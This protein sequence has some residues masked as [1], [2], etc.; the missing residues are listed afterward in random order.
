MEHIRPGVMDVDVVVSVR[1]S[2][3][4]PVK[5]S[6]QYENEERGRRMAPVV[7]VRSMIDLAAGAS[8]VVH[9]HGSINLG[10]YV[11]RRHR[12]SAVVVTIALGKRRP[13]TA[14]L[15]VILGD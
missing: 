4:E 1:A 12:P 7:I 8:Q 3:K 15:P 9:V 10:E 2:V 14:T 6:Y 5:V 11:S 13:V